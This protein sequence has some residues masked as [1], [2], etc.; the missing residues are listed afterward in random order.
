M[1]EEKNTLSEEQLKEISGGA[2]N[3]GNDYAWK[4][5]LKC[6]K[7]GVLGPHAAFSGGRVVCGNCGYR[8]KR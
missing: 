8:Y 3:D 1:A 2:G 6:P 5:M 4:I 7:C